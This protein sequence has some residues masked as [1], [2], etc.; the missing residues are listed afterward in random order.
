VSRFWLNY[1]RRK[2]GRL[3]G[4]VILDSPSL[5][6]AH[7][8][9]AALRIDRGMPFADGR[10]LGKAALELVPAAALGRMLT[11]QEARALQESLAAAAPDRI[12][13]CPAPAGP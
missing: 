10:A 11:P 1:R 6:Q 7:M 2:R 5:V 9:A 12:A 4:A 3:L 13:S 8:S